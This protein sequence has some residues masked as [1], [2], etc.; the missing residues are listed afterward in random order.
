[1]Q[2]SKNQA[3]LGNAVW[4][5]DEA[6]LDRIELS[7]R[8]GRSTQV[9]MKV[10]SFRLTTVQ[11]LGTLVSSIHGRSTFAMTTKQQRSKVSR[12]GRFSKC[13]KNHV[14]RTLT[15]N[16]RT[17]PVCSRLNSFWKTEREKKLHFER[18]SFDGVVFY[19][20]T[21][22]CPT[23]THRLCIRTSALW[24]IRYFKKHF[25]MIPLHQE[26]RL[27]R[28]QHCYIQLLLLKLHHS[29]HSLIIRTLPVRN[30]KR[31]IQ[32]DNR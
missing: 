11:P 18:F 23:S 25:Y 21:Y 4:T 22:C 15:R 19:Q 1:M 14:L 9:G 3:N 13:L 2:T 26:D 29:N 5:K 31:E 27:A 20:L 10:S 7:P 32:L 12:F 8:S 16:R 6:I 24:C 30:I 28:E 17:H